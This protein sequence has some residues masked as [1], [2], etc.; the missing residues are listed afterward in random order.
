[1]PEY[2]YISLLRLKLNHEY[3]AP[4]VM[5]DLAVKI[6]VETRQ[7][8][9]AAG[10]LYRPTTDG[11]QFIA[12]AIDHGGTL[13]MT[14]PI[15]E[16]LRLN[17]FLELQ[18]PLFLNIT[19]GDRVSL[20]EEVFYFN[21]NNATTASEGEELLSG[22]LTGAVSQTSGKLQVSRSGPA[23]SKLQV[24]GPEAFAAVVLFPSTGIIDIHFNRANPGLYNLQEL[25]SSDIPTGSAT[26]IFFHPEISNYTPV[27]VLEA[28]IAPPADL[29]T[30]VTY[31][32]N[33]EARS[34]LW[35]YL[36]YKHDTSFPTGSA[37]I[38]TSLAVDAAGSDLPVSFAAAT[39]ADPV[40]IESGGNI[41]LREKP[42]RPIH[43]QNGAD[44][45]LQNLANPDA[46]RLELDAGQ[47]VSPINLN[48]YI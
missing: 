28:T 39:G 35:R 26:D 4:A 42:Y 24:T 34:V 21:T 45:V 8:L 23:A 11:C 25:D 13:E 47:W 18:N 48:L 5:R 7:K 19:E 15:E 2:H 29:S 17:L 27:I 36:I 33:F 40:I 44:T 10:L 38:Y 12:E 46:S 30:A 37:D 41:K 31:L 6:P 1:M 20:G 3:Y 9:H 32:F 14:K 22:P 43:L 16:D